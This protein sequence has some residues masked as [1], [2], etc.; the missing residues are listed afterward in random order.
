MTD[1]VG[2]TPV[3]ARS[4]SILDDSLNTS[5]GLESPGLLQV[6]ARLMQACCPCDLPS[7]QGG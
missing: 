4:K 7:H 6:W 1:F 3:T 2:M 5:E